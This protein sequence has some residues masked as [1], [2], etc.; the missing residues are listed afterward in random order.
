MPKTRPILI[1]SVYRP[2]NH[3]N[4]L[5]NF[6][7]VAKRVG[8][9]QE[10]FIFGDINICMRNKNS[11]LC[12]KYPEI[13]KNNGFSQLIKEPTRI[14]NKE[15]IM[16]HIICSFE[17]K[18]SQSGVLPLALS[19][20]FLTFSTRKTKKV[21]SNSYNTITVR[22][23]KKYSKEIFCEILKKQSTFLKYYLV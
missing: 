1:G 18:I 9:T 4:F 8:F 20:H 5:E 6:E 14:E 17:D 21:F 16:D 13:L 3:S 23:M 2:L 19:D 7:N 12:K 11:T 22:S 10:T 15:S